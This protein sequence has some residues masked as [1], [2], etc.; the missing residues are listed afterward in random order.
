MDALGPLQVNTTHIDI[1]ERVETYKLNVPQQYK[2]LSYNKHKFTTSVHSY[3]P[4][5]M[6]RKLRVGAEVSFLLLYCIQG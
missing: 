3:I 6:A 2:T 4:K 5:A 1:K